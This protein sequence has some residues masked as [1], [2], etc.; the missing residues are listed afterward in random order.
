ISVHLLMNPSSSSITRRHALR[1]LGAAATGLLTTPIFSRADDTTPALTIAPEPLHELSP[2]LYMQFMEPLGTTAGSVEAA[3]DHTRQ[4]W[5]PDLSAATK[6]LAP[7]M[8]RWG[9]LFSAYS[10]WR[11]GVGPRPNR[12]PMHNLNWGG[13]ETNQIGTA[14]FRDFCQ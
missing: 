13:V 11:E 10:R 2:W 12:K 3:W 8:L 9:G 1:T 5:R 7:P 14:E 6:D 4:K